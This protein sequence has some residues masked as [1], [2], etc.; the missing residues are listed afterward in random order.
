ME[1][2]RTRGRVKTRRGRPLKFGR[3]AQ[4]V[5]LTLPDD[6]IAWLKTLHSDPAWAVVK[7]FERARR[8]RLAGA[9]DRPVAELVQLPGRRALIVVQP[10]LFRSLPGISPIP[11]QDGRAFLALKSGAGLAHLE[12]AVLDR[13][14]NPATSPAERAQLGEVRTIL[15]RW[16]LD[17]LNFETRSIIVAE[18]APAGDQHPLPLTDLAR[19]TAPD[20]S[21]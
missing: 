12:I 16:R 4:L 15:K 10:D 11:L 6:V 20:G 3:S 17:G 13:L 2:P 8:S 9:A 7:L 21:D 19:K 5:T 18:R 1:A 14:E